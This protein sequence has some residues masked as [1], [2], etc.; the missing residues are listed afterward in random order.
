VKFRP[1]PLAGVFVV[2]PERHEDERGFFARTWCQREFGEQGLAT[3]VVQCSISYNRQR[4]T[5]RGMHYQ[6]PPFAEDKLVRVT[7]GR[8][9]DVAVD[10]RPDSDTFLGWFGVELTDENRVG[11]FIPRGFAHG[12][13]TLA[14]ES[15]VFYQMSEFYSPEHGRGIRWDEARVNIAWPEA[16]RVIAERDRTYADL[17]PADLR[18][19]AGQGEGARP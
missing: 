11:L 12:F 19:F 9:F 16:V 2:E 10:L 4:G 15:E 3:R 7:R 13:L 18:V 1:T 6:A 14:D 8:I 17:Q 5:L